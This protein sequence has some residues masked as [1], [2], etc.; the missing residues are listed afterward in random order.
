MIKKST[1]AGHLSTLIPLTAF[2][3]RLM[4]VPNAPFSTTSMHPWNPVVYL[5]PVKLEIS[6]APPAKKIKIK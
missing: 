3:P 6:G 2:S 4:G 5:F 1:Y